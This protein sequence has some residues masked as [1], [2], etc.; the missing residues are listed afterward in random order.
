MTH[1]KHGHPLS[2]DN[3]YL[4]VSHGRHER[5]CLTCHKRLTRPAVVRRSIKREAWLRL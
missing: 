2:G 1:C 4:Y 5:K 3:L